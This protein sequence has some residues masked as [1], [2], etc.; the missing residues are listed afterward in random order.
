MASTEAFFGLKPGQNNWSKPVDAYDAREAERAPFLFEFKHHEMTI[1]AAVADIGHGELSI[2]AI[3]NPSASGRQVLGSSGGRAVGRRCQCVRVARAQKW[4]V[5]TIRPG[6]WRG[7]VSRTPSNNGA[8]QHPRRRAA[9]L[10]PDWAIHTMSHDPSLALSSR[11]STPG[12]NASVHAL[13]Q[14]NLLILTINEGLDQRY[15]G[16]GPCQ[17]F[18]PVHGAFDDEYEAATSP[19]RFDFTYDDM[20]IVATVT[21]LGDGELRFHVICNPNPTGLGLLGWD[22]CALAN[23]DV[24]AAGCLRRGKMAY[25][26]C[27]PCWKEEHRDNQAARKLGA[28]KIEPHGFATEGPYVQ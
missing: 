25:L 4:P 14:L 22:P 21:D 17:N 1:S 2:Q 12:P 16:L 3:C 7:R 6:R 26:V 28:L 24:G 13:E 15:F 20:T 11:S 10:C 18:W 5:S 19:Y 27:D 8:S 9:G 23:G